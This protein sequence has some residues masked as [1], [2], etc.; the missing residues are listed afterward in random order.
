M[1]T[2]ATNQRNVRTFSGGEYVAALMAELNRAAI[3][4][5]IKQAREEAGLTQEELAE[6]VGTHQRSVQ[7]WE[8][9]TPPKPGKR[10]I[11]PWDRL[12]EIAGT[13]GVDKKWI[14]H[15]EAAQA[16]E[17][18]ALADIAG[19]LRALE[20]TVEKMDQETARGFRSLEEAIGQLADQL[21]PAGRADGSQ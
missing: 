19:R 21:R 14:I 3:H 4:E 18:A 17:G 2:A 9:K 8:S 7:N 6:A 20:E 10:L 13:T 12:D 16:A 5:R 15:G 1:K 11:V